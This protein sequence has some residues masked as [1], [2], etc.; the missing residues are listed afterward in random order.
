MRGHTQALQTGTITKLLLQSKRPYRVAV[1]L[2]GMLSLEVS[3]SLVSAYGLCV[4]YRLTGEERERLLAAEQLLTAKAVALHY[5]A[6]RPRT[7]HEVRQRLRREGYDTTVVTQVI[8]QLHT[9]GSLDDATYARAYLKERRDMRRDGPQRIRSRL[10]QRGVCQALIDEAM[11]QHLTEADVLAAAWAQGTKY[12]HRLSRLPD[13]ATRRQKL[14]DAL[15][16]RGF[17]SAIV[18]QVVKKLATDPEDE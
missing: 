16:R 10:R 7:A 18:W 13:A 3:P 6:Y 1:F 9:H 17:P 11:Q 4:G 2:D 8:E 14:G 15:R 5:M 12:W